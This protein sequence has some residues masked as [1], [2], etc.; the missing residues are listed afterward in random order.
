MSMR[1]I[2][3]DHVHVFLPE[4]PYQRRNGQPDTLAGGGER[5]SLVS[6]TGSSRAYIFWTVSEARSRLYRSQILQVNTRRKA[7]DE[8]YMFFVAPFHISVS[9]QNFCTTSAKF[10]TMFVDFQMRR[11]ILQFFVKCSLGFFRNFAT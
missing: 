5:P 6:Q 8:I 1:T 3:F 10:D 11:Q 9:F 7:L 2:T 4:Y